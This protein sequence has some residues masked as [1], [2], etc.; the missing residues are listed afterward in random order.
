MKDKFSIE[1]LIEMANDVNA[2][3]GELDHLRYYDNDKYFFKDM[4]GNDIDGA[5]RAV[6]YGDY[7]YWDDYVTWNGYGNLESCS[8]LEYEDIIEDSADEIVEAFYN[9]ID[10]MWEDRLKYKVKE[11]MEEK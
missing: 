4:Y 9:N 3:D 11:V 10:N 1:E 2:W 8:K 5:I 7:N 6:C